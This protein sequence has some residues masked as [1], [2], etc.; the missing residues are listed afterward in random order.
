MPNRVD[1]QKIHGALGLRKGFGLCKFVVSSSF[2]PNFPRTRMDL[3]VFRLFTGLTKSWLR[4][5]ESSL[6][7]RL[8]VLFT[9]RNT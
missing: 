4:Y 9:L 7:D 8:I 2:R 6:V 3:G 1:I 5:L